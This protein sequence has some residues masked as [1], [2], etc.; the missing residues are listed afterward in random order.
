MK[1]RTGKIFRFAALVFAALVVV[2]VVA[3]SWQY[4]ALAA[5]A[6]RRDYELR[7]S[8]GGDIRTLFDSLD[9]S[10][11]VRNP[12]R[13]RR[14]ASLLSLDEGHYHP[15]A[16]RLG[17]GMNYIRLV[18]TLQ[19]GLQSPV[20]VTFNNIRSLTALAAALS[21][22]LEPDSAAFA[23]TLTD[24]ETAARFGFTPRTFMAMFIPD[25]YE[26]YWTATPVSF[27]ERMSKEYSRFWN[28]ERLA[29]L[30]PLAMTREQVST[31]A[32]IVYEETKKS[33]E[34]ATVAGVY[35][36]RLRLGMPL[37]ADPTVKFAVGDFTL[38]RLLNCHKTVDSP[39]NTYKYP[40]LPPGPISMPSVRAIDAVLGYQ[41]HNYLYFCAR[42][43]FSGYHTFSVTLAQHERCATEYHRALDHLGIR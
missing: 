35:I 22:Q 27:V 14:A 12:A 13:L 7:L 20:R 34:M 18:R 2:G 11:A 42:A 32:S 43:D 9:N 41:H 40:G 3:V 25:T 28:E 10:G 6:M 29:R 33:D 8:T 15:G 21:R 30:A 36:N 24:P 1:K 39:Y 5:P 16:Y 23:R 38:K 26:F 17:H 19:R 31:L 37:Q 4:L